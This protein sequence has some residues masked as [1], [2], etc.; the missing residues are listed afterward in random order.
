MTETSAMDHPATSI[1]IV[2]DD[3]EI[4]ALVS[5]F[6]AR[7]GIA[8]TAVTDGAA[9]RAAL[10]AGPFDLVILD[11][12]LPGEDGLSLCRFLRETTA[13]P[14]IMLT[15]MATE[16]DRVI[17][18]ETG[19]DDY[20]AKPFSA[21]ELLARIKAVLRRTA[22]RG[23]PEGGQQDAA[24]PQSVLEFAG[25]R[26]NIG[27]RQLHSADGILVELTSGEFDLLHAFLL[28]PQRILNRDQLLDIA[29]GRVSG[30]FD[31]TIDVQVGRL[32]RKLEIDPKK[33]ELIKTVRG[34]GY[35]LACEVSGFHPA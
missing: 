28:N 26:L 18:L 35:M 29:R 3:P 19:A 8:A 32:R 21:R 23:R 10:A 20:V 2:D 6:L 13:L 14:I 4:A 7:H 25:W 9:M 15:A 22:P 24:P 11:L 12:M 27:R 30:P 31:R 17:G 5:E 33:P 34:G 1:L 16:P